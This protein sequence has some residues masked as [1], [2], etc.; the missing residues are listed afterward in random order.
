MAEISTGKKILFYLILLFGIYLVCEVGTFGLSLIITGKPFSFFL[1]QSERLSITG[2]NG[3]GRGA[4]DDTPLP[5]AADEEE[6]EVIHPYLGFVRNPR[7]TPGHNEFGFPG[8]R[9]PLETPS[10][11]EMIVGIFGGSFAE[12]L[13]DGGGDVLIEELK[14]IPRFDNR[15]ISILTYAVGGYK[16]PQQFFTLAYFLSLGA[17]FDIV[18][19]LDGFNELVLPR[20]ENIPKHVFPF[21]PRG[22]FLR[23]QSLPE[24]D[25]LLKLG[26][27]ALL[28][29]KRKKWA[30]FFSADPVRWSVIAN[31]AWKYRDRGLTARETGAITALQE[32][33]AKE[34]GYLATGPSFHYSDKYLDFARYWE[35]CSILMDQ[36]CRA[37][38]IAYFHVLQPNQHVPGS[39]SITPEEA[40]VAFSGANTVYRR[41][42]IKGYPHLRALGK[43][44]AKRGVHFLDLSM[45]FR[46]I[47][48]PLYIDNCCHVSEEGYRMIGRSIGSYITDILGTGQPPPSPLP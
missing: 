37:N 38:G 7:Q 17:H 1:L 28:K 34:A 40:A 41:A 2:G 5:A 26:E 33:G 20:H 44:L 42:V 9:S 15:E 16:Q 8:E 47:E 3:P 29:E 19:N 39:K 30:R 25:L 6:L 46:G 14:S 4:G 11:R 18:I 43:N 45:I 36:L 27:I 10:D 23:V 21:Y 48:K 24:P 35:R 31:L 22:W 13:S 12:G 32:S